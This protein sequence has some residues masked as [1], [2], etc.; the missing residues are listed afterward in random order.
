MGT[1]AIPP[2]FVIPAQAGIQA[3]G[4]GVSHGDTGVPPAFVIPAQAGIQVFGNGVSHGGTDVPPV[5]GRRSG[6]EGPPS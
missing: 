4:N 2:A 1:R 3:F 5:A 6:T